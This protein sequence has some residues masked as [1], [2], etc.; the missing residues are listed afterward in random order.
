[1]PCLILSSQSLRLADFAL[2][3]GCQLG[4]PAIFESR[5]SQSGGGFSSPW[6]RRH[7]RQRHSKPLPWIPSWFPNAWSRERPVRCSS[8]TSAVGPPPFAQ[9][10][11]LVFLPQLPHLPQASGFGVCVP[12]HSTAPLHL[13]L[14]L[15]LPPC[16]GLTDKHH[17]IRKKVAT[18]LTTDSHTQT[19]GAGDSISTSIAP[20]SN[21]T[22]ET[23]C[24][25]PNLEMR[26]PPRSA[27]PA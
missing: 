10:P 16:R 17:T 3:R 13:L 23:P 15:D 22:K 9:V 21:S 5:Q 8:I 25:R 12:R 14:S 19:L 20:L 6:T 27:E 18:S 2:G 7:R 26:G 24:C 4:T 1:M 11:L